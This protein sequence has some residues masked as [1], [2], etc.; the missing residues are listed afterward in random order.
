MSHNK[1]FS[2]VPLTSVLICIA[3]RSDQSVVFSDRA[4]F[5]Q[6]EGQR[7]I[8]IQYKKNREGRDFFLFF[9]FSL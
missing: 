2:H 9:S 6:V 4:Q 3:Q 5:K 8:S 7:E 1:V